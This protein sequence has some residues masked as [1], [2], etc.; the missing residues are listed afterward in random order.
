[1]GKLVFIKYIAEPNR[2]RERSFLNDLI[3]F[4]GESVGTHV[5][6]CD[7]LAEDNGEI[8]ARGFGDGFYPCHTIFVLRRR[9][10][11]FQ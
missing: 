6:R 9:S 2:L 4:L 10:V 8:G 1:M 3:F 7:A 11:G 5:A